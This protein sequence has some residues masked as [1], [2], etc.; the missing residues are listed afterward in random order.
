MLAI[1]IV[2]SYADIS[3]IVA[4]FISHFFSLMPVAATNGLSY[5]NIFDG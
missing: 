4:T 1:N 5:R 2:S 3:L